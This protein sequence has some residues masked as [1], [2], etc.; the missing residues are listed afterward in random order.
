MIDRLV[1]PDPQYSKGSSRRGSRRDEAPRRID[2]KG[3][4]EDRRR[5]RK[6][7]PWLAVLGGLMSAGVLAGVVFSIVAFVYVVKVTEDLPAIEDL[8]EYEPPV[9]SRVQAGDGRLIAEYARESRVF[10]PIETI[11]PRVIDAFL[12]AEDKNFYNHNGVEPVGMIRALLRNVAN[13]VRG[14]EAPLQGGSTITQQVAKN[15]KVGAEQT[16]ERKVR[17]IVLTFRIEEAF[18]KD[19]ILEL[20]LNEIYL[21]RRAYGVAAASLLYFGKPLDELTLSE[22]AYLAALPRAPNNYHPTRNKDRAIE[23]RNLVLDRMVANGVITQAEADVAKRD[24]LVVVDR[25][26]GAGYQAAEY[27]VEEVRR[28]AFGTYGEEQ[29]YDGGL[30]IRTTLDTRLQIAAR[31]ALR[32]GLEAYDRRHGYRGPLGTIETGDGWVERLIAFETPAVDLDPEWAKAVVLGAGDDRVRIGFIDGSE[33]EIPLSELTSEFGDGAGARR[34]GEDGRRGSPIEKASDALSEGEVIYAAPLGPDRETGDAQEGQFSLRQI[35]AINGGI[36]AL[37]PHTGR[38][39]ALV[40]GYSYRLSQFN[41]AT[42][43]RRQPGSSFKPFVYA[44]A[45][46][47]GFTPVSKVLDAP[48]VSPAGDAG[49]FYKPTNYE[50]RWYGMMTLR[51]GIEQSRN[52]MTVRLANAMGLEHMSEYAERFGVYDDLPPYES[53]SLGAGETTL[54]R[55]VTGYGEFVNGGLR[56]TPTIIDR[57]QDRDGRTIYRHDERVCEGCMVDPETQDWATAPPPQLS[58]PRE[59]VIDAVTAYQMVSMLQGVV[60]RGTAARSVGTL[61]WPLAGKTGTSNDYK[62]VWFVGFSPDLVA[63]VYVGFDTPRS[64]GEGESGGVVAAPIFRDFMAV[65]LENAPKTPF[66]TP[67]GV[68]LVPVDGETGALARQGDYGMIWEAFRPGTEPTRFD[69]P[70]DDDDAVYQP[71]NDRPRSGISIG[72]PFEQAPSQSPTVVPPETGGLAPTPAAPPTGGASPFGGVPLG[73]APAT[74]APVGSAPAVG[75]PSV[76]SPASGGAVTGAAPATGVATPPASGVRPSSG[77]TVGGPAPDFPA[78]AAATSA[79]AAPGSAAQAPAQG[80]GGLDAL[81]DSLESAGA[82]SAPA[83][84]GQGQEVRRTESEAG[85][86]GIY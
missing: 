74:G 27:F 39:L 55:M 12:S 14:V 64:L 51:R 10:V 15:F 41:R 5:R 69:V 63:G 44:A 60:D 1:S 86:S 26:E 68:R 43:A 35:P 65:A 83:P 21:G 47:N 11:P 9:M 42:Q 62:D 34:V 38:V 7:F 78:A 50:G 71:V 59:R 85:L 57:V 70:T 82:P 81:L 53:M 29:L 79:A 46:D 8:A 3:D 75:S 33:G 67:P 32:D 54:W 2:P 23:R 72:G 52:A 58:D 48:Y 6:G 56:I 4:R 40:G 77:V 17:E 19:E 45:L 13:M 84:A 30:S 25:F 20:Y 49:S 28:F 16:L 31:R 36:L 61:D 80:D 76:G 22:I 18:T 37:D 66:R 24:D 73:G